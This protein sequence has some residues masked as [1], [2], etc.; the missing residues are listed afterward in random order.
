[1]NMGMDMAAVASL[2]NEARRVFNIDPQNPEMAAFVLALGHVSQLVGNLQDQITQQTQTITD[3][4][5]KVMA[6]DH[7]GANADH[8]GHSTRQNI[9]EWKSFSKVPCFSGDEKAFSDFEFKLHTFLRPLPD[10]EEMLEWIKNNDSE[11]DKPKMEE[12]KRRHVEARGD[13]A[14]DLDYYDDQLYNVL[15]LVC[16]STAL[17]Q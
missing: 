5:S 6:S 12:M 1:M 3:L 15:S 9:S 14:A 16:D 13:R 7:G 17:S 11:I 2:G 10:F 8:G 4:Q